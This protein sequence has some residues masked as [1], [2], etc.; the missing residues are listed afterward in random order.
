VASPRPEAPPV[1]RA[2]MPAMFMGGRSLVGRL[3]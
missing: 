3:R 1:I 2:E